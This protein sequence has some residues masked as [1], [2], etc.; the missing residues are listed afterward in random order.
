MHAA[1]VATI[2]CSE[3][4]GWSCGGPSVAVGCCRQSQE[5]PRAGCGL[6]GGS[7]MCLIV[8]LNFLWQGP[9]RSSHVSVTRWWIYIVCSCGDSGRDLEGEPRDVE[10]S[11][12]EVLLCKQ[13]CR[14]LCS[15]PWYVSC[16]PCCMVSDH[17]SLCTLSADSWLVFSSL[18]PSFS[19]C[20]FDR[21]L[22]PA[23]WLWCCASN[24]SRKEEPL[25]CFH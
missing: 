23:V 8:S 2:R 22:L 17:L 18:V 7:W 1:D 13:H 5:I 21:D 11:K 14:A 19:H 12:D 16:V 15:A 4:T 20:Q 9:W 24:R 25:S 3:V 6:S 10:L